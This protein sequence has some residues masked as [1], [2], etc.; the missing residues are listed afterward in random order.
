M[1]ARVRARATRINRE[2]VFNASSRGCFGIFNAKGD[3]KNARREKKALPN[4]LNFFEFFAPSPPK[5][6]KRLNFFVTRGKKKKKS[7]R[8]KKKL[9]N[10]TLLIE[11]IYE[12][13]MEENLGRPGVWPEIDQQIERGS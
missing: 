11:N 3:E 2:S 9:T 6:C 12:R 8:G 7:E 4:F 13:S 5:I 1:C 10:N